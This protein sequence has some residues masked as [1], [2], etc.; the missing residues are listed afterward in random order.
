MDLHIAFIVPSCKS[1]KITLS[2]LTISFSGIQVIYMMYFMVH[3]LRS[4]ESAVELE[5]K[6][7][8]C[9]TNICNPQRK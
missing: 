1:C 9:P 3:G 4:I 5:R 7:Q 2:H 6:H 8:K